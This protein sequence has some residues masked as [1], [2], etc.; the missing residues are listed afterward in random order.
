MLD[1][2]LNCWLNT[3]WQSTFV[4][5]SIVKPSICDKVFSSKGGLTTHNNKNHTENNKLFC[6]QCSYSTTCK[7]F[8]KNHIDAR[9]EGVT[10]QCEFCAYRSNKNALAS[11]TRRCHSKDLY[12]CD[13]CDY[14]NRLKSNLINH[15]KSKHGVGEMFQCDQCD[16]KA[17]QKT[18]LMKHK[19]ALHE[20]SRIYQC[21][22]CAH[23][24]H[25]RHCIHK[26]IRKVHKDK[27]ELFGDKLSAHIENK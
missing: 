2:L 24:T 27:V 8:L 5:V 10:F 20:K 7:T 18:G 1:W 19:N 13:Q 4:G 26:H 17:L 11:H 23:T 22:Y 12:L 21:P 25:W 3:S 16:Y 9:H 6:D 15:K 14:S